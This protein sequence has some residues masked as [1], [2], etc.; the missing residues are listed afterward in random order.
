MEYNKEI[1]T[2]IKKSFREVLLLLYIYIPRTAWHS[3]LLSIRRDLFSWMF[4][5]YTP[6]RIS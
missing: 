3:L 5:L 2:Q 4:S 6:V 1:I